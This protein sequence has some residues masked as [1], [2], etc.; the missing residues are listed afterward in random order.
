MF[1][2]LKSDLRIGILGGYHQAL[3]AW[4]GYT[5]RLQT[6]FAGIH[7]PVHWIVVRSPHGNVFLPVR[8]KR[9]VALFPL[10][11]SCLQPLELLHQLCN[12]AS[13]ANRSL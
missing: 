13:V 1:Y 2:P 8:G 12:T 9:L 7:I 4:I 5:D 10:R 11:V 3:P 6:G